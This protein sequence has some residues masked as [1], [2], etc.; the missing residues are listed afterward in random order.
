MKKESRE[1]KKRGSIITN[2][3]GIAFEVSN[4]LLSLPLK[5]LTFASKNRLDQ[6]VCMY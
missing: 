2:I 3:Y 1:T 5:P 6:I 4:I